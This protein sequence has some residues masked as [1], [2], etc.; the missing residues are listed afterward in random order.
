MAAQPRSNAAPAIAASRTDS[1]PDSYEALKA[2]ITLRYPSLS[3]QLQ[4]IAR[5]VLDHPDELA[6]ETV[7]ALAGRAEVQP[8]SLV[9]FA[10]ALDYE[11]FSAMQ[12]IFRGRLMA[13]TPSYRERISALR[14]SRRRRDGGPGEAADAG[15]L[16]V[17]QFAEE[18]IA[19]LERLRDRTSRASVAAAT[20]LLAGAEEIYVLAQGRAFPVAFYLAYA[21]GRLAC[22]CRLLDGLGGLLAQEAALATPRDALIAISF[23]PYSPQVVDIV[24]ER[25]EAGVPVVAITDSA[26]SPL[27]REARVAF[28]VRDRRAR[29]F[30]SLVAPMCLA[31]GLVVALG[32]RLAED[33][34]AEND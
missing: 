23:Q 8:S 19:A 32:N 4:K 26:L 15:D 34:K 2:A 20:E 17:G 29:P 13:Q 28:E 33:A 31:Q 3:R 27:A 25:R 18:G 9:R 10:Q 12:Q 7:T 21:L 6:L 22:R 1:P 30:R 16:V 14:R 11:G 5:F 24:S